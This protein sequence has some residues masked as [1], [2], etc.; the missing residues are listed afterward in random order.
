M[1]LMN[2][3]DDLLLSIRRLNVP[4]ANKIDKRLLVQWINNQRALWLT[5]EINKGR[6]FMNNEVQTLKSVAMKPDAD[7]SFFTTTPR[8]Y[9]IL[10]SELPLPRVIQFQVRDGVVSVRPRNK[11]FQ[12]FNYVARE[13]APYSGNGKYNRGMIYFFKIDDYLYAK[14]ATDNLNVNIPTDVM[15][16]GIFENPLE[17]DDFNNTVDNIW[18]G[19]DEYPIS[20]KFV[21]YLKSAIITANFAQMLAVPS[22]NTNNDEDDITNGSGQV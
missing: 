18:N 15:L 17:V 6:E 4:N 20:M 9:T 19:I 2:I 3:V 11:Q 7:S 22:D 8:G 10:K 5:N 14:Y 12:R 1:K 13:Q 21:E 16:E